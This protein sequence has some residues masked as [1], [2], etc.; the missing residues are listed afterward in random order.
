MSLTGRSAGVGGGERGAWRHPG[1]ETE[2]RGEGEGILP[3][4]ANT[5]SK[6]V[7]FFRF[8]SEQGIACEQALLPAG[9]RREPRE[10]ARARGILPLAA[11]P[12]ARAFSRDPLCSQ[13][14]HGMDFTS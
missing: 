10:N 6:G 4:M 13:A 2:P 3:F 14:K 5:G 7:P 12:L 8:R 9:E 11:L 1:L